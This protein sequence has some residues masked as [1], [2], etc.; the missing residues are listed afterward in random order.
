MLKKIYQSIYSNSPKSAQSYLTKI[1]F[2]VSNKPSVKFSKNN[3][4]PNGYKAGFVISADF[5]LAWAWR[6]S[7]KS[8]N[9]LEYGLKKARQSR[10]NVPVLLKL[11]ED[12]NIPITWAIVGHLFLEGCNNGDHD[13]MNKIPNFDDHWDFRKGSWYDYDPYSDYHKAPEWYAPDLVELILKSK[14]GHEIGCHSFSHLH[15]KDNICPPQVAD[16]DIKAC[17]DAAKKWNIT[18]K[19]MVFPGGTNGNYKT[20]AKHGFTN[21]RQKSNYELFYPELGEEGMIKLPSSFSIEDMGFNWTKEYYLYRYKKYIDKAIE[22]NTVCHG[23]FHPSENP[24][25]IQEVFPELLKYVSDLR[26]KGL[27]YIATMEEMSG[28]IKHTL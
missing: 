19:S 17:V 10:Q 25:I 26:D 9:P 23:W 7:K 8:K 27:L 11:F 2:K 22:T 16:D 28:L 15:F 12:Y 3:Y 4:F 5:E 6:Y 24:W 1:S 14:T 20:L 21:Y 13:W 18:L